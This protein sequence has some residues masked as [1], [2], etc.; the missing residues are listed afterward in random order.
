M[1]K[2]ASKIVAIK[3]GKD[4]VSEKRAVVAGQLALQKIRLNVPKAIREATFVLKKKDGIHE[5]GGAAF[6]N[7]LK[8]KAGESRADYSK[9]CARQRKWVASLEYRLSVL[10]SADIK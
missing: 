3:S 2:N 7:E 1:K 4:V 10:D 6:V 9:R 5:V 8:R